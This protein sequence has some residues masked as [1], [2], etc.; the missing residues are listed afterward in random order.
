M[1]TPHLGLWTPGFTSP[2]PLLPGDQSETL[3]SLRVPACSGKEWFLQGDLEVWGRV[4]ERER[5]PPCL[6]PSSHPQW[7]RE[8]SLIN[9]QNKGL[10]GS[11]NEGGGLADLPGML[12]SFSEVLNHP[13]VC[14]YR[15][16]ARSVQ[17]SWG[18]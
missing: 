18:M 5:R 14:G 9:G 3:L 10:C 15:D 2:M 12:A 11:V 4:E 7:L 16:H 1:S 6:L 8:G 17:H 13:G